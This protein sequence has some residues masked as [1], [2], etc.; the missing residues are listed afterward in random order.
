MTYPIRELTVVLFSFYLFI[1]LFT[2]Y[3]FYYCYRNFFTCLCL[4]INDTDIN[5]CFDLFSSIYVQQSW[6]IIKDT[7]ISFLNIT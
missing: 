3:F 6:F 7:K 4:F 2:F 5:Q 1:Y